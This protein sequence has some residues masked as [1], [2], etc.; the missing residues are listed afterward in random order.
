MMAKRKMERLWVAKGSSSCQ[1]I[2]RKRRKKENV[3]DGGAAWIVTR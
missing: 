3:E 2:V 1:R